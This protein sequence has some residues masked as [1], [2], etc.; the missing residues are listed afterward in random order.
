MRTVKKDFVYFKQQ[1]EAFLEQFGLKHWEVAY[2]HRLEKDHDA[3]STCVADPEH[4]MCLINLAVDWGELE[5]VSR[6][7]L[8]KCALHEVAE[9]MLWPIRELLREFYAEKVVN[10]KIHYVIRILEN[11]YL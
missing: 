3:R 1:C 8:K 7:G 4:G 2:T 5:P 9:L 6:R 11:T 10:D